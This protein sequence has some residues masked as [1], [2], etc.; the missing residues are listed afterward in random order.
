MFDFDSTITNAN[1]VGHSAKLCQNTNFYE[2]YGD[3]D[4][5][6]RLC[7]SGLSNL[8]HGAYEAIRKAFNPDIEDRVAAAGM[9]TI[10][11][12]SAGGD[13]GSTGSSARYRRP[14]ARGRPKALRVP[15]TID[16]CAPRRGPWHAF[17]GKPPKARDATK[18]MSAEACRD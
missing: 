17:F 9:P 10:A 16:F 3:A 1:D 12:H 15:C 4:D 13:S 8:E 11:D 6:N 18:T 7:T 5:M 14:V 2:K